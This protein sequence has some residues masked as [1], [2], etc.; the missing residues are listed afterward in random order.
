[1]HNLNA[2]IYQHLGGVSVMRILVL[3]LFLGIPCLLLTSSSS[4]FLK[5]ALKFVKVQSQQAK[6]YLGGIN[7]LSYRRNNQKRGKKLLLP[8]VVEDV[9]PTGRKGR[10]K[11]GAF[12][13]QLTS[14]LSRSIKRERSSSPS[15]RSQSLLDIVCRHSYQHQ[16]SPKYQRLLRSLWVHSKR[17]GSGTEQ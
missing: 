14:S 13:L 17:I 6:K 8:A 5:S 3:L 2:F 11:S 1:M 15:L 9:S 7:L 12:L 10:S 4:S 16:R